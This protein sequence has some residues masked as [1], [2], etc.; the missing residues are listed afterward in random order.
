MIAGLCIYLFGQRILAPE[1]RPA[2]GPA[3]E[4]T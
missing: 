3:V 2:R 4:R 1:D